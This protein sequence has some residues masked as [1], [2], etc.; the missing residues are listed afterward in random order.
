MAVVTLA[1]VAVAT[2]AGTAVAARTHTGPLKAAAVYIGVTVAELREQLRNGKSLAQVATANGKSVDGLKAAILAAAKAR[3]DRRV[4]LGNLKPE[5][6]AKALERLESGL[7][8]I[9]NRA[10]PLV[11]KPAQ[12][13]LL[14]ASVRITAAYTGLTVPQVREQLRAGKSLAQVAEG[15]G[16][17]VEGLKQ[18][19]LDRA[20]AVIDRRVAA[21]RLTAE[22]G[23]RIYEALAARIDRLLNR[24]R[25]AK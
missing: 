7:D 3:L 16:K 17:S 13:L 21:G 14:R 10:G 25:P 4:A 5:R 2:G 9:V 18:R 20:K 11:R 15:A 1:A 24:T 6:A 23:Q 22:R 8:R 12:R 19:M